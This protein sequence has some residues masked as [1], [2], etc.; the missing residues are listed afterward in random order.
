MIKRPLHTL[1]LLPDTLSALT[2][3]GYETVDDISSSTPEL[4]AKD[5]RISLLSSQA[6]FSSTQ[7]QKIPPQT[8]S[9][10]SLVGS[11]TTTYT[12]SC[13]PI[14]TLLGGGLKKGSVLEISGP[15][16]TPK[17]I[18]ALNIVKTFVQNGHGVLF[19]GAKHVPLP[20][21]QPDKF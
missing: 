21:R 8:Q 10:A 4:L 9:A 17:E 11:F 14:D 7:V 1:V 19:V 12:T 6:V 15:P 20:G 18:I 3:A 2:R 5:A 16:G 13:E